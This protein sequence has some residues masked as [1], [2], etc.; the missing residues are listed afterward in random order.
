EGWYGTARMPD[1]ERLA[2]GSATSAPR[3]RRPGGGRIAPRG[4]RQSDFVAAVFFS[5][6]ASAVWP[7][8]RRRTNSR[9]EL[10]SRLTTGA[11]RYRPM[12]L[13]TASRNRAESARLIS[14]SSDSRD[15]AITKTLQVTLKVISLALLRPKRYVQDFRP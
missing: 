5:G 3:G 13:N 11:S 1:A 14:E 6:R 8:S 12:M 4:G 15:P 7:L 2:A 9:K 10:S